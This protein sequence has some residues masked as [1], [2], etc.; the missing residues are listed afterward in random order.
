MRAEI[1]T[2]IA[3]LEAVLAATATNDDHNASE[4]DQL[5]ASVT[6]SEYEARINKRRAEREPAD[7][8]D[9]LRTRNFGDAGEGVH[10]GYPGSSSSS[11]SDGVH[12]NG[13]GK[14]P[15]KSGQ[16]AGGDLR[17]L[18]GPKRSQGERRG[19]RSHQGRDIEI[20]EN[21]RGGGR[22]G[23]GSETSGGGSG[24]NPR[25]DTNLDTLT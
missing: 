13:A 20:D 8:R 21:G 24:G 25:Y 1:D 2:E 9:D 4:E 12:R 23:R 16:F 7:L 18:L 19:H 11:S 10:N 5:A 15:L 3:S 22:N 14:S 6:L 17:E